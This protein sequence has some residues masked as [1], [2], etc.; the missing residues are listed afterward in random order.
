MAEYGR[1]TVKNCTLSYKTSS[2]GTYTALKNLY[3]VPE[4]SEVANKVN[5]TTFDSEF[6]QQADGHIPAPDG[7]EFGF[8]GFSEETTSTTTTYSSENLNA[9]EALEDT[10]AYFKLEWTNMGVA[11]EFQGKGRLAFDAMSS[12]DDMFKYRFVVTPTLNSNGKIY[13]KTIN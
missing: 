11:I 8:I 5:F 4:I 1:A 6:E 12:A 2:S 7:I 13:T 10:D 9:L 3:S